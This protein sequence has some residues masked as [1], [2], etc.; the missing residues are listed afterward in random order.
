M[1]KQTKIK[2]LLYGDAELDKTIIKYPNEK[3]EIQTVTLRSNSIRK[4][5]NNY[6]TIELLNKQA[7]VTLIEVINRL[8]N[9]D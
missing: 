7:A 1:D 5:G 9:E 2:V 3:G 4:N 8:Q 6:L